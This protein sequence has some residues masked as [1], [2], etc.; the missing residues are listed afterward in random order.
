VLE[1]VD[2]ADAIVGY[3]RTNNV[4]HLILGASGGSRLRRLLGTV[5]TSIVEHAP[6]TVTVVRQRDQRS[7]QTKPVSA[8]LPAQSGS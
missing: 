1:H 8:S 3:V 7:D 6:C 4:E 5:A 2:P